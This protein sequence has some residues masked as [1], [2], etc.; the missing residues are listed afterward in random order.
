M[1]PLLFSNYRILVYNRLLSHLV[2]NWV[3]ILVILSMSHMLKLEFMITCNFLKKPSFFWC[4][5]TSTYFQRQIWYNVKNIM[6][7]S[8]WT[9][10]ET[11]EVHNYNHRTDNIVQ[12]TPSCTPPALTLILSTWRIWWAPNNAIKWQ[13]GFH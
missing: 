12:T 10:T 2:P 8:D 3:C 13:V 6:S 5:V 9:K 11:S 7:A 4:N 1:G